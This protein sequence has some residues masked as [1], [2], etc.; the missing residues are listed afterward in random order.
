MKR[1]PTSM[2]PASEWQTR[3]R[4][5]IFQ[6]GAPPG[7]APAIAALVA[8]SGILNL[9]SL[10]GGPIPTE[11]PEWLRWMFPLDFAEFSKTVTLLAGFSL[12]LAAIHLWAKKQ[13][14]WQIALLLA[15]VS[16]G[17]HLW[18]GPELDEAAGSGLM[19]LLLLAARHAFPLGSSRPPLATAVFRASA[20]FAV[21]GLYGAAGFWLLEPKEFHYNFHWWEAIHQT[22]RLMLFIGDDSLV[23]HT[24]YA[25]WFVDSLFWLSA[26]AFLYSGVV[27]F[28][29]VAY[30]FLV[31]RPGEAMAETIT[32]QYGR[33]GQDFFKHWP[34]KTY[35][36]SQSQQSFLGYRVAGKL[37]AGAGRPRRPGRG[38]SRCSH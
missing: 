25:V 4:R 29:P 18:V 31:D 34:D 33:T 27:L 24:A 38:A 32:E 15:A 22:V 17:L 5:G 13:R 1:S 21:V 7:V 36:F 2:T 8:G 9:V 28:R 23:P 11:Q 19:V 14:A 16:T 3:R 6:I 10:M 12:I 35:F 26:A 20:A 37:R 30:R